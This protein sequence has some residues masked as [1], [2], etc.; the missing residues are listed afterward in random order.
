[1]PNKYVPNEFE[2]GEE[3]I[4]CVF[5]PRRKTLPMTLEPYILL[6]EFSPLR[7]NYTNQIGAFMD[8]EWKRYFV[9]FKEQAS[10]GKRKTLLSKIIWTRKPIVWWFQ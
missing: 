10:H 4:V 1:L 2:I 8:G 6:N 9:P 7:V 5:R 3:L